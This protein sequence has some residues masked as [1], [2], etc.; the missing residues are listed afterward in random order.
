MGGE[1]KNFDEE[2]GAFLNTNGSWEAGVNG[3][4]PGIQMKA[5]PR[6]GDSYHQELLAGEAEDLATI[7]G[8]NVALTLENGTS[9][10]TLKVKEWNPLEADSIEF[11]YYAEGLGVIREEKLD[12]TGEVEKAIELQE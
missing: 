8:I 9:H 6:V 1:A 10:N 7:V 3:A 5:S 12:V 11:K 4:N 2:T